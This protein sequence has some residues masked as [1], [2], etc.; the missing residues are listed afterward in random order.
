MALVRAMPVP[1]G[2]GPAVALLG[3]LALLLLG[4]AAADGA[5]DRPFGD[6]PWRL[7]VL[8]VVVTGYFLVAAPPVRR[9]HDEAVAA[10]RRLAAD[11]AMFD[12]ELAA[13][14]RRERRWGLFWFGFG[15]LFGVTS[16]AAG[17]WG[18]SIPRGSRCPAVD[19][20]QPAK[21]PSRPNGPG[22][23]P[24]GQFRGLQVQRAVRPLPVVVPG[25]LGE[26]RA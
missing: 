19:V 2:A 10:L 17:V 12:A 20:V 5:L 7:S 18:R 16:H 22:P 9:L 3:T 25:E 23:R 8:N 11:G 21:H 14:R 6:L 4:A 24:L 13:L 1:R 26:H 15:A